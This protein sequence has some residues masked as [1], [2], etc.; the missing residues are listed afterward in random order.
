DSIF[1]FY[2]NLIEGNN[3]R[4]WNEFEAFNVSVAQTFMKDRFGIELTYDDQDSSWSYQNAIA[5]DA[6]AI[7]VDVMETFADGS[8][9]PGLGRAMVIFG[10]GSAGSGWTNR[11]RETVRATAFGKFDFADVMERE[12]TL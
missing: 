6:A 4:N 10:G 7:S 12:S 9:N 3:K 5:G 1:D 2:N 11:T 8:P